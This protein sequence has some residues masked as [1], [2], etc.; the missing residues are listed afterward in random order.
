MQAA[1]EMTSYSYYSSSYE[2][3]QQTYHSKAIHHVLLSDLEANVDYWYE[4]LTDFIE[5][6]QATA[7]GLAYSYTSPVKAGCFCAGTSAAATAAGARG[8]TSRARPPS[9]W[10]RCPSHVRPPR[11]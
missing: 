8:T 1:G 5:A 2:A 9:V 6:A 7:C 10:R 11:P 4:D 3:Q